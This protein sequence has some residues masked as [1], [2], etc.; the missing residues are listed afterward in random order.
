MSK[1]RNMTFQRRIV[2]IHKEFQNRFILKFC[3]IAL[4]AMVL[5]SF[6]LYFFSKDSLTVTYR[7]HHLALQETAEVLLR[8]L[9]LSNL[10]VLLI[11]LIATVLV[12][13]YVSHKI[14]GPLY[15]L[16]KS[17]ESIGEGNLNLKI[18]F[19]KGDQLKELASQIN[20]MTKNLNEKVQELQKQA[21][22]LKEK[23]K[24]GDCTKED[25]GKDIEALHQTVHRL[26]HTE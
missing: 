26:F 14:A 23:S 15:G 20:Q 11:L 9:I 25:I 19:R 16:G 5:A 6:L 2:Y 24:S 13:M 18:Q 17:L 21:K 7:Y 8:P 4:G 22:S 3:I 12:T 1:Q 10:I